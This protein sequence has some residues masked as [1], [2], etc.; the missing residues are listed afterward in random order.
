MVKIKVYGDCKKYIT[1][2]FIDALED[3]SV[4]KDLTNS[5][6]LDY[7][8]KVF[9]EYHDDEKY[10][11]CLIS[12][13]G[14]VLEAYIRQR[15]YSYGGPIMID[16]FTYSM[17][18]HA[19]RLRRRQLKDVLTDSDLL[20]QLSNEVR[21]VTAEEYL[22]D[23]DVPF[24]LWYPVALRDALG[25][26]YV[27]VQQLKE[28]CEAQS[29]V[30]EA[31]GRKSVKL[32]KQHAYA[33]IYAASP[34]YDIFASEAHAMEQLDAVFT[35]HGVPSEEFA[36]VCQDINAC[37]PLEVSGMYYERILMYASRYFA[38]RNNQLAGSFSPLVERRMLV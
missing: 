10:D 1:K 37:I 35:Q 25:K 4:D 2:N 27:Q 22:Q 13:L 5:D 28:L 17:K 24:L 20:N 33:E 11:F 7:L 8:S 31:T 30:L 29:S 34:T 19:E 3:I 38:E 32:P 15:G 6:M 9:R 16:N 26:N 36:K 23:F 12:A 14:Q 18:D 21:D